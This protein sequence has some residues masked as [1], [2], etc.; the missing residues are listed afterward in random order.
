MPQLFHSAVIT[1]AGI[2]LLL[3]A[4]AGEAKIE[5]TKLKTGNGSY[6]EEEKETSVLQEMTDLKSVK[7]SYC[8]S[9][10]KIHSD[11]CVKV[12][13]L[14]TNYDSVARKTLISEGYYINEIGLYAKEKDVKNGEE[15]L[16]SIAVTSGE[17]GDF[18]PPYNGLSPVEIIQEYY[19]TVSNSAEVV[20][21]GTS[22]A[23]ALAEDLQEA[24]KKINEISKKT[25]QFTRTEAGYLS[26]VASPVQDQIDEL[27]K[28]SGIGS[29][30][31][32][33]S[34]IIYESNVTFSFYVPEQCWHNN[35]LTL[36]IDC[37]KYQYDESEFVSPP[38]SKTVMAT[39]TL[40]YE[41]YVV[42]GDEVKL[43]AYSASYKID[44]KINKCMVY[45]KFSNSTGDIIEISVK[46]KR[47]TTTDY[48]EVSIS[49]SDV[50][51][52]AITDIYAVVPQKEE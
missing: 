20:I 3:K 19:A 2:Q 37:V 36:M 11:H 9:D 10:V 8:F 23:V 31:T 18:M 39:L 44:G 34:G 12:T 43:Q 22:K 51:Q 27:K 46:A 5:F 24:E 4:Q 42:E 35:N 17:N 41:L 45:E 38:H 28:N 32:L 30:T 13:S 47:L 21:Q 25:D 1:N 48:A 49:K 33:W 7:N 50:N 40:P 15:V 14:I 29:V 26:G 6:A 16:Y 52:Y